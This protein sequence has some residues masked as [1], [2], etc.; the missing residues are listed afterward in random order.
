MRQ[1]RHPPRSANDLERRARIEC[2]LAHERRRVSPQETLKG[3]VKAAYGATRDQRLSNVGPR[4][5]P[6]SADRRHFGERDLDAQGVQPLDD[7]PSSF[8]PLAAEPFECA[9]QNGVVHINAVCQDVGLA[10]I[11]LAGQLGSGEDPE[12]RRGH[13]T[14]RPH[15]VNGVVVGNGYDF[16][17]QGDRA[18]D[19]LRRIES[20]VG[21][22]GVDME[23]DRQ[24]VAAMKARTTDR[25]PV[26]MPLVVRK[27]SH[28][29]RGSL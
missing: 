12:A 18:T 24:R 14:R 13:R 10:P 9:D 2:R 29:S 28:Q 19:Q 16:E 11:D 26:V 27:T 4:D 5:R 8:L 17:T 20:T 7:G 1:R 21:D 3:L 15:A 25:I 6:M 22:G 23:I